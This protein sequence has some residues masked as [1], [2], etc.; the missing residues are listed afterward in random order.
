MNFSYPMYVT[1]SPAQG[2]WDILNINCGATT[3][4]T[5]MILPQMQKRQKG[6]IVNVSSG[7]ELQPLPLMSVYAASKVSICILIAFNC[8]NNLINIQSQKM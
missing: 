2:M 3:L 8:Y 5:R 7:S 1:E 6:A 4:M